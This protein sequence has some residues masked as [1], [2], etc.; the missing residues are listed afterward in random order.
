MQG[1]GFGDMVP[2]VPTVFVG[3]SNGMKL[4]ELIETEIIK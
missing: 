3:I 4:V 2:S 1:M